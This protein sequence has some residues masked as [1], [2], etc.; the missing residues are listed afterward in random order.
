MFVVSIAGQ[1]HLFLN[2]LGDDFL[3]LIPEQYDVELNEVEA[4][5]IDEADQKA[6]RRAMKADPGASFEYDLENNRLLK[7]IPAQ[8]HAGQI[9]PVTG[10]A[11]DKESLECQ[12]VVELLVEFSVKRVKG[13]EMKN[14][15]DHATGAVI[16]VQDYLVL[17]K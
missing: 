10:E 9:H 11:L 5:Y 16:Q 13:M 8:F 14:G 1:K 6:I 7:I 3:R 15:M 4:F 12:R 2:K 17:E